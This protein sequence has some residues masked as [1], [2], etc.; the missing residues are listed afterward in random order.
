MAR[1]G[2]QSPAEQRAHAREALSEYIVKR[3]V[4][5]QLCYGPDG[6]LTKL[7]WTRAEVADAPKVPNS[8][9]QLLVEQL[10]QAV[11]VTHKIADLPEEQ[12][13]LIQQVLSELQ[14]TDD[15]WFQTELVQ[16]DDQRE[17]LVKEKIKEEKSDSRK[18]GSEKSKKSSKHRTEKVEM[19][20]IQGERLSLTAYYKRSLRP[21]RDPF[22]YM[23]IEK[24]EQKARRG[25]LKRQQLAQI[26]PHFAGQQPA[27]YPPHQQQQQVCSPQHQ[28]HQQ[29]VYTPQTQPQASAP[30]QAPAQIHP[31]QHG[32]SQPAVSQQSS[33]QR[34]QLQPIPAQAPPVGAHGHGQAPNQPR[35]VPG[36]ALHH[37]GQQP[38]QNPQ[39]QRL[40]HLSPGVAGAITQPGGPRPGQGPPGVHAGIGAAVPPPPPPAGL[41]RQGGGVQYPTTRQRRHTL[42][43]PP[44]SV[45]K[46]TS[47]R[48]TVQRHRFSTSYR[49]SS[50][51]TDL[52]DSSSIFSNHEA[53][54]SSSES[55]WFP[56]SP[57]SDSGKEIHNARKRRSHSATTCPARSLNY[58]LDTDELRRPPPR[59]NIK[60]H[61]STWPNS[62]IPHPS[63]QT[64]SRPPLSGHGAFHLASLADPISPASTPSSTIPPPV[65]QPPLDPGA[66]YS[67]AYEAGREAERRTYEACREAERKQ[68]IEMAERIVTDAMVKVMETTANINR[69]NV[70]ISTAAAAAPA[71]ANVPAQAPTA[72]P[73]A[74]VVTTITGVPP[75]TA[76]APTVAQPTTAYATAAQAIP[77]AVPPTAPQPVII[78][79][80]PQPTFT[81][82]RSRWN[83][84]DADQQTYAAVKEVHAPVRDHR[85]YNSREQANYYYYHERTRYPPGQEPA[86]VDTRRD[87]Y[88]PEREPPVDRARDMYP[89]S[90]PR[91]TRADDLE[92][93]DK[94]RDRYS[95][96]PGRSLSSRQSS[97][98]RDSYHFDRDKE[99]RFDPG[100]DRIRSGMRHVTIGDPDRD[101]TAPY[102]L[103]SPP[104]SGRATPAPPPIERPADGIKRINVNVPLD[105]RENLNLQVNTGSGSGRYRIERL[106]EGER[107]LDREKK[108]RARGA[109]GSRV[110]LR[111]LWE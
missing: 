55:S 88:A 107:V 17:I 21:N 89:P 102:H 48:N 40:P 105:R 81:W 28:Q 74:P 39:V 109:G 42:Q 29:Q 31:Q 5:T 100:L 34:Q 101:R 90:A 14:E 79:N 65:P 24:E 50:S 86:V 108:L 67:R 11:P 10:S 92:P 33:V 7:D 106:L 72:V 22:E 43:I 77:Q 71:P 51:G 1:N 58:R 12:Q 85:G 32:Q 36:Q 99:R 78:Q 84:R 87:T 63:G 75:P 64:Y 83:E 52:S 62:H 37:P 2:P 23:K 57:S 41:Q 54:Y 27:A 47:S 18:K 44:K 103:P 46:H 60:P 26:P 30:A 93:V 19:E 111:S 49:D 35:Q 9:I 98:S 38:G 53:E 4:P 97:L 95:Y 69:G 16:L 20:Y 56:S 25:Q 80:H 61:V 94:G 70:P 66:I 73:V 82:E 3:F 15:E 104:T 96:P 13:R 6:R 59:L 68:V 76:H 8:E 110:E 45:L 91:S